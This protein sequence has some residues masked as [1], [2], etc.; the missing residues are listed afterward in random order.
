VQANTAGTWCFRATYTPDTTKFTGSS[1]DSTDECVVVSKA[2]TTTVTAPHDDTN[3]G[4][5]YALTASG[6]QV[7][8]KAT[9]T[10]VTNG[11]NPTGT[12]D[13]WLCGP[14][15]PA[16]TTVTL[17]NQVPS[18]APNTSTMTAFDTGETLSPVNG[19]SIAS[20]TSSIDVTITQV[21]Q[22]CF[23]AK[24]TP[25]GSNGNYTGS[26]DGSSEECFTV[27][28]ATSTTSAQSWVPNDSATIAA[29]GG[30]TTVSGTLSFTLYP[31]GDCNASESVGSPGDSP[32]FEQT[33]AINALTPQTRKTDTSQAV[34]NGQ[35]IN[36]NTGNTLVALSGPVTASG[37]YSWSDI[38]TSSNSNVASS[39]R[40]EATA[41]TINNS[42]AHTP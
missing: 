35:T 1:D 36:G 7:S 27:M 6:V 38:F 9:V 10:G 2:P 23:Y 21:G 30:S 18:C 20:S 3:S 42:Q 5:T 33:F 31:D 19:S 34:G 26:D 4:Q 40:C 15:S 8:D 11:G 28:D 29:T 37:S 39:S 24:F 13:F 25:S 22:Y 32:I 14:A 17:T 41:V 12:V 16:V